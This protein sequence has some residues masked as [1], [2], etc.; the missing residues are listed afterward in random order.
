[1]FYICIRRFF[2]IVLVLLRRW[3]VYGLSNLPASGGLVIVSNHS[4]YWDPIV[5]GCAMTR[6]VNYLAKEELF[7]FPVFRNIITAMA[8]IPI[9]R[10]QSDRA[11]IRKALQYLAEGQI[12]GVFPEGARNTGGELKAPQLGAAMLAL[13]AG[14]PILPLGLVG[15]RGVIRKIKVNVG[16]PFSY[17][18]GKKYTR[19]DLEK[20]SGLIMEKVNNLL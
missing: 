5:V 4:S 14:V 9:K 1:M 20:L 3:E 19:E 18:T 2:R 17:Q 6:R 8:A 10:N 11:A 13:K 7:R 16:E 15:T 12:I